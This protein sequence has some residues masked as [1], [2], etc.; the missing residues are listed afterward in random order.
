MI[1]RRVLTLLAL[2]AMLSAIIA[3]PTS[4]DAQV[5]GQRGGQDDEARGGS[6]SAYARGE[7]AIA[8]LGDRLP[9]V[10][11]AN[12]LSA[13]ELAHMLRSDDT[14]AV[15]GDE[16]LLYFDVLAPGETLVAASET[17]AA[18]PPTTGPE[19]QLSSNPGA[20]KTI[21]LDFD[22]HTT[23]GTTWNSQ[24][25]IASIVSAPYD[26]DGDPD[27]WSAQE[28]T[29]IRDSWAVV[30]EDFAPWDINVTTIDPGPNALLRSGS[31]DQQWGV[32]VL[33]TT[34]N[35]LSCGC[36]GVAYIGS[37]DDATDE[38]VFVFNQ[39]FVGVSEAISH[40]VGHAMLL[41]HD[42]A[43]GVGYY[44][45]HSSADTPGWAPIMGVGYYEPVSQWSQQEYFEANNNTSSANYGNGPD[46][47]AIIS[48]LTNGNNFGLRA[49]DHGDAAGS[50][51][52]L[53]TGTPD[54]EGL[55]S[56]RVDIDAFSF[57]TSGGAISMSANP[58][59]IGANLDI[60]LTLRNAAG[61][62]VASDNP[63][64]ELAASLTTTVT[65]GTYTIEVN[66]V[67]VG[68]PG[69][70]PPTGYSDYGSLGAYTLAGTIGGFGG[71]GDTEA[72]GAPTGLTAM[73]DGTT[74]ELSWTANPEADIASYTVARAAD[75]GG[76]YAPIATVTTPQHSDDT[77]PIGVSWYRV[78]AT[79]TSAN[80]SGPSAA[81]SATVEEPSGETT[82]VA[83][84]E[85]AVS[86]LVDATF[87]AT[88]ARDGVVQTL[89]ER[90]SGGKPQNRYD[91]GEHRWTLPAASGNQ[92]IELVAS[93]NDAGDAD[94]GFMFEWSADGATWLPLATVPAG[95]SIDMS[96]AI[97]GPSGAIQVRV[98]DTDRTAGELSFDSVSVDYIARTGSGG[99]VDPTD[100]TQALATI[101]TSQQGAGRGSQY[102]VAT[103]TV[104]DDQGSPV[105]GAT[106][107]VQFS[108]DFD[109]TVSATTDASGV[110]VAQT[111]TAVK[112]PTF[113][114]CVSDVVATGLTWLARTEA[115]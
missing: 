56:T 22:G 26:T 24:N 14:L 108:G 82:V 54:L 64:A 25:G 32:R 51:T 70:N 96:V 115:C 6:S 50:A 38:P 95:G 89:T 21:Y 74:V 75:P 4:A 104:I 68:A 16:G 10:A 11:R 113:S 65:A 12:G 43:T 71:G 87:S 18:A 91:L 31:G 46:D 52:V 103:V 44:T 23:E 9:A 93:A 57:T 41:A 83:N 112:K 7:Q 15:D 98:V 35:F 114:A 97:G 92:T 90:S 102:G 34:D 47:I 73:V 36:G 79:D 111:S 63:S 110:A 84:A 62:I 100:P 86:G 2:I 69:A 53:T 60:E 59:A 77:A 13:V 45:G 81:V 66:G 49:D 3:L 8:R 42:G 85:T 30:A 107:T 37:F 17:V 39:S 58:A 40:E 1:Q 20:A 5:R 72:P 109:E 106:V 48:S 55:I 29:V 27:T 61:T 19:F 80:E 33:M 76:P 78:T 101:A 94:D 67:G 105:A 28:L 99:P 88:Q